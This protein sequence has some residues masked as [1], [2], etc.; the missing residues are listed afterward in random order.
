MF[1]SQNIEHT[2]FMFFKLSKPVKSINFTLFRSKFICL[3][4]VLYPFFQSVFELISRKLGKWA[5]WIFL[6]QLKMCTCE[7]IIFVLM[8]HSIGRWVHSLSFLLLLLYSFSVFPVTI[9]SM[10]LFVSAVEIIMSTSIGPLKAN[11]LYL[12]A[13]M[14]VHCVR[15]FELKWTSFRLIEFWCWTAWNPLLFVSDNFFGFV[16]FAK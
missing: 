4:F 8:K 7:L 10:K 6:V 1:H 11:D 2:C 12:Y 5:N 9:R 16:L 15:S 13:Q 3:D 14:K